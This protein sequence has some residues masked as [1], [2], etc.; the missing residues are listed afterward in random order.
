MTTDRYMY[1][2]TILQ[3]IPHSAQLVGV[4]GNGR[5]AVN[6]SELN[7]LFPDHSTHVLIDVSGTDAEFCDVLDVESGDATPEMCPAWIRQRLSA[8]RHATIYCARD[9]IPAIRAT[10][11]GLDY[12]LWVATLDGTT[13]YDGTE[14]STLPGVVAVQ[15][16]G[17]L[18]T[19]INADKSV[20]YDEYWPLKPKS[21]TTKP[22][23]TFVVNGQLTTSLAPRTVEKLT[24]T[25]SYSD[26]SEQV[27][28]L[29][30]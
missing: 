12:L 22:V 29:I 4:Y 6:I 8:G 9:T 23:T 19:G 25:V 17:I 15:Y 1:D 28:P 21:V 30:N 5:Y 7:E 10:C 27:Y 13:T 14:L 24:V 18:Q 3:D 26:G 11:T 2:S 16:E 20:V